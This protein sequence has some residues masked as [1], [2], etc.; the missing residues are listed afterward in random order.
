MR[1]PVVA[2]EL[3]QDTLR[4]EERARRRAQAKRPARR[5]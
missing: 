5:H 1:L 2:V 3:M 4:A